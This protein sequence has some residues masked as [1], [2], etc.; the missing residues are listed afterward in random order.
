MLDLKT[1][2]QGESCSVL[3]AVFRMNPYIPVVLSCLVVCLLRSAPL[4]RV[5][6]ALGK[7]LAVCWSPAT[8]GLLYRSGKLTSFLGCLLNC[9]QTMPGMFLGAFSIQD[10]SSTL[11][12]TFYFF[13]FPSPL[14]WIFPPWIPSQH[15]FPS[16]IFPSCL[17]IRS[18]YPYT[19]GS[20]CAFI[21][22]KVITF[23]KC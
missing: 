1:R 11:S 10:L 3:K 12:K 2:F 23:S 6:E 18:L 17:S 14:K 21:V 7:A 9:S 16:H 13:F 8:S 19:I 20:I 15:T 22:D 4:F 5:A